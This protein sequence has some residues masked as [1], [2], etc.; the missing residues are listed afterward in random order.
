[1]AT[2]TMVGPGQNQEPR[3][4]FRSPT[5]VQGSKH[6]GHLLLLSQVY[7][8]RVDQKQSSWESNQHPWDASTADDGLTQCYICQPQATIFN[9]L[10]AK[11]I[12]SMELIANIEYS[13][14]HALGILQASY[15]LILM[16]SLTIICSTWRNQLILPVLPK[17]VQVSNLKHIS[18]N[19]SSLSSELC[20]S[21]KTKM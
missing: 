20:T 2:T 15:H 19:Q 4:S 8:H 9:I 3:A 11:T 12:T 17:L 13:I 7:H 1:M 10:V 18:S 5:W 16:S 6:P 14:H 21:A